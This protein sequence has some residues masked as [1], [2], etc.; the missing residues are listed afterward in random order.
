MPKKVRLY[1][2]Y[3][4]THAV[5][6]CAFFM[7][8]HLCKA[9]EIKTASVLSPAKAATFLPLCFCSVYIQKYT[10]GLK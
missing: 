3:K 4:L 5:I 9:L 1:G 8:S 6:D 2:V 7:I 10:D